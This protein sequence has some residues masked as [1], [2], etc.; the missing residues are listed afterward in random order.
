MILGQTSARKAFSSLWR[1][2]VSPRGVFWLLFIFLL[3]VPQFWFKHHLYLLG[4]DD[5]GLSYYEPAG[6]LKVFSTLWFSR[7]TMPSLNPLAA[8]DLPFALAWYAVRVLAGSLVNTQLVAFGLILSVSYYSIVKLLETIT[9]I[10]DTFAFPIAGLFFASSGYFALV[11]YYYLI[12]STFVI[13]LAPLLTYCLFKSIKEKNDKPLYVVAIW[14]FFLSRALTTPVFINFMAFL[15][16]FVGVYALCNR[17]VV[18]IWRAVWQYT[19]MVLGIIA[20]NAIIIIPTVAT[21]MYADSNSVTDAVADRNAQVEGMVKALNTE[22]GVV[23]MKDFFMNLF[24]LRISE[25][26]GFRDYPLYGMFI[27]KISFLAYGV[28]I[29]GFIGLLYVR[30][31]QRKRILFPVISTFLVSLLFL[32]VDIVPFFHSFY[33]FLLEKTFFF[34]MNR[35]PSL[36]F[37]IPYVFYFALLIGIGLQYLFMAKPEKFVRRV[38]A[39]CIVLVL[40]ANWYLLSGVMFTAKLGGEK[41]MRV[42]DFNGQYKQLLHDYPLAVRDDTSLFLFPLGYGY[43]SFVTGA[44]PGQ[45]YRSTITGFKTLAGYDMFGNLR[46]VDMATDPK[47]TADMDNYFYGNDLAGFDRVTKEIGIKYVIYTKKIDNLTR[48]TE[49]IPQYTYGNPEYYSV[50]KSDPVYEN[51]GYA[52]YPVRGYDDISKISAGRTDTSLYFNKVADFAYLVKVKS[53]GGDVLKLRERYSNQWKLYRIKEGQFECTDP[54]NLATNHPGWYECRHVND[55]IQGIKMLA[56]L[57]QEKNPVDSV[58]DGASYSNNWKLQPSNDYQYYALVMDTQR[59]LT[60][61]MA[62]SGGIIALLCIL[63]ALPGRSRLQKSEKVM[64]TV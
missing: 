34:N 60:W 14:S 49:L 52:I 62:V 35:F 37:H 19:K 25:V 57:T 17:N 46:V 20:V 24:P 13:L 27:N 41:T 58:R 51:E 44:E 5:T 55:N 54:A 7:D 3:L 28:V 33:V 38:A 61:G 30:S 15:A 47:I 63:L 40:M 32:S 39:T 1:F 12:P 42:L 10:K 4:D 64:I 21:Y 18:S 16:L 50:V 9:D 6:A 48:H 43:G 8:G 59:Y 11:E 26:Q 29:L 45:I 22:I 53:S 56:G 36:K 23:K 31:E 2:L